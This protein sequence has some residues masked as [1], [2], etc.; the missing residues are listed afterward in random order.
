MAPPRV[1]VEWWY[2]GWVRSKGQNNDMYV[3]RR[4][5]LGGKSRP[6]LQ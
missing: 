1:G 4:R 6:V 5:A 2:Q 3:Y